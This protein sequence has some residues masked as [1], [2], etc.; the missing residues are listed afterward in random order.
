MRL[1]ALDAVRGIASFVVVLCHC[2]LA[3]PADLKDAF[4]AS[5]WARPFHAI[6]NG[7]AAVIVFFM[8]S[9]YVLARPF[10]QGTQPSYPRFLTKRFCRIYIPFAVAIVA[11]AVYCYL[12]GIASTPVGDSAWLNKQMVGAGSR[13]VLVGHLLMIGTERYMSLDS[14]MWTLV[15]EMR[16]AAVFPLLVILC[17]DTRI[18]L[19]AA[20]FITV[21][22]TRCL[23]GFETTAP[24]SSSSLWISLL[25]TVRVLPYFVIGILLSKHSAQFS[26]LLGHLPANARVVLLAVP[27]VALWVGHRGY[28]SIRRD[29]LFDVGMA[30]ALVLALN[31]PR[32][33]AILNGR[34]LQWLGRISYSLYLVH[35]PV[36]VFVFHALSGRAP[37]WVIIVAVI[38]ASSITAI[39]MHRLIEVPAIDLGRRFAGRPIDKLEDSACPELRKVE[40]VAASLSRR[41]AH[42]LGADA[43]G[44]YSAI[45]ARLR[46]HGRKKAHRRKAPPGYC[47]THRQFQCDRSCQR[48]WR[49]QRRR[50]LEDRQKG[51]D[52]AD[53]RDRGTRLQ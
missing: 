51:G 38:T 8:L 17:R 39:I 47:G 45:Q 29:V 20:V 52:R 27:L 42:A 15:C 35:T 53:R 44:V 26:L 34:I 21:A 19:A 4:D 9:G 12:S 10:F 16:V 43:A 11:T 49:R 50:R 1:T 36:L 31:L 13:S 28:L 2:Y 7:D 25:W 46:G 6:A 3:L 32:L 14:P 30:V 41:R 22:S 18:A 48:D 37:I 5:L 33:S 23:V 24:W 40:S